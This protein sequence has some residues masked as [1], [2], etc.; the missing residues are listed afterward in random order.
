MEQKNGGLCRIIVFVLQNKKPSAKATDGMR[1]RG[2]NIERSIRMK[3]TNLMPNY[4]L[5]VTDT[6]S[7]K[8]RTPH[9]NYTALRRQNCVTF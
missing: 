1:V 9:I 3:K 5:C 4:D 8:P 2:V 7:E 6:M